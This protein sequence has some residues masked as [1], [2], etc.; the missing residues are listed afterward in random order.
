MNSH[1]DDQLTDEQIG[2]LSKAVDAPLP[3]SAQKMDLFARIQGSIQK[4][5]PEGSITVR[6]NDAEWINILPLID[7]KILHA[8]KERNTQIAIWRLQAG[9]S[10]PGHSHSNDEECLMLEG[11]AHFGDHCVRSGDFHLI[12]AGFEHPEITTQTGALVMVRGE[13]MEDLAA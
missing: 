9:A 13:Y 5:A 6:E 10:I 11:E 2:M 1:S 8:D 12:K 3:S 4:P 7:I